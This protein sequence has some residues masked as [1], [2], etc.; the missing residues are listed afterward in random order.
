MRQIDVFSVITALILTIILITFTIR[1]AKR[2][3][4]VR[5]TASS[6]VR[7]RALT[8]RLR[9]KSSCLVRRIQVCATANRQR[10][11]SGCFRRLGAAHHHRG[12]LRCF[13]RR[14]NSGSTFALLGSTVTASRG[15]DCASQ[16]TVQ[17][18]TRT[19]LTS[20]SD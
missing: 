17:L 9:D 14:C 11:V 1:N 19:A 13:T 4:R 2:L 3:T 10:C 20:R 18:I 15:L 12:T 8:Q 6:C 7:Y 16:C 5:A